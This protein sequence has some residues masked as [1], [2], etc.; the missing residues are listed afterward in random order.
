[1]DILLSSQ[2]RD[3]VATTTLNTLKLEKLPLLPPSSVIAPPPSVVKK[4]VFQKLVYED[5]VDI[6]TP[7]GAK[8]HTIILCGSALK[9]VPASSTKKKET[10]FSQDTVKSNSGVKEASKKENVSATPQSS[11]KNTVTKPALNLDSNSPLEDAKRNTVVSP[12][13]INTSNSSKTRI[14][15]NCTRT[16]CLKLY[17]DCFAAKQLCDPGFCSCENCLNKEGEEEALKNAI[18]ETVQRN[19]NAFTPK[20]TPSL[21]NTLTHS[22]GCS[23]RR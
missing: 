3:N 9:S 20:V 19:P 15:C 16:K 10:T 14:K 7:D 18:R 23:C 13:L 12:P 1:M 17:C 22:K 2:N 4:P 21:G 6:S 11:R 8:K 5:D